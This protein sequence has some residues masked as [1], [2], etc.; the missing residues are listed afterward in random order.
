[1]VDPS[2]TDI[3]TKGSW[4]AMAQMDGKV[5]VANVKFGEVEAGEVDE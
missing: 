2:N 4:I 3:A 5:S 1:M